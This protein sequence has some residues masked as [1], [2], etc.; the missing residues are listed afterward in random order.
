MQS[1]HSS[2]WHKSKHSKVL[3]IGITTNTI[4]SII[5]DD[6]IVACITVLGTNLINKKINWIVTRLSVVNMMSS[7]QKSKY[8][9]VHL[10]F[11]Q[12]YKPMSPQ[13]EKKI[14]EQQ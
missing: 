8:N 4:L 10:K 3:A 12:C 1:A 2:A 6:A 9:D 7:T 5:I 11:I 13:K 14:Q